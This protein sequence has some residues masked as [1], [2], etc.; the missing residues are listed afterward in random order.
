MHSLY[1]LPVIALFVMAAPAAAGCSQC[2]RDLSRYDA[3][4]E[5]AISIKP[6]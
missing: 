3:L 2:G 1:P 5:P 6:N 4:K